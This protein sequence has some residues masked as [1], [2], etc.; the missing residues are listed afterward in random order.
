VRTPVFASLVSVL[1]SLL[2]C[3]TMP[4]SAVPEPVDDR[5]IATSPSDDDP[6]GRPY[7]D[8]EKA[9]S[10]GKL[11]GPWVSCY[12]TFEPRSDQAA[13]DLERLT[14]ACG[15]PT[16]LAPLAPPREG[17]PQGQDD[18]VER[19]TFQTRAGR[20][21][22]IFAVGAPSVTDLDVAVLDPEGRLAAADLSGDRFPVVPPRGPLCAE[23][24]GVYTVEVSVAQGSGTYA[25]QVLGE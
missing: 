6:A 9:Q 8:E 5:P 15:R 16:G 2:G 19:F 14:S 25:I 3:S 1:A 13:A 7:S 23:R 18:P 22:R 17:E 4:P 12:R 10:K 21:Y 11:G 24:E 20:C